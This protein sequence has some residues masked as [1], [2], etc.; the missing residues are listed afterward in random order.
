MLVVHPREIREVLVNPGMG[1]TTFQ[2]FQGD[3]LN[4]DGTWSEDGPLDFDETAEATV[5]QAYPQTSLAYCRWCWYQ[6]EPEPGGYR[7]GLIDSALRV[8]RRR[9]QRLAV[10]VAP[11]HGRGPVPEWFRRVAPGFTVGG[12]WLPDYS[13]PRYLATMA[14]LVEEMGRRYDGHPDLDTVDIAT[15]GH[16]GEWHAAGPDGTS[17]M[18]SLPVKQQVIDVY[19]HAFRRTPLLMQGD[20]EGLRYA[21]R[22]GTGWRVDCLG[23]MRQGWCHM[24]D[25]YPQLLVRAEAQ[26][27]WRH[28]PVALET[29]WTLPHWYAHGWDVDHIFRKALD[30]HVTS[31][32]AKSCPVPEPWRPQVDDLCRRMGYRLVLRRLAHPSQA[33]AGG[34]LPL[35]TYWDNVGVA[36]PYRPYVL[37]L[38][39]RSAERTCV[40]E[41]RAR[42]TEWVPGDHLYDDVLRLPDGMPPGTYEVAVALLDPW[43]RSPCIRLAVE[44]RASDGWY[45][46]SRLEVVAATD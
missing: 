28:A 3:P 31:I 8:A 26:D 16:C 45:P 10:R 1:F 25:Q 33:L 32:N 46:L 38:R 9:G 5:H 15:L 35:E 6:I 41:T 30:W 20:V 39:L 7:W 2:R 19:L 29:C 42:V 21:V 12:Q 18:P 23:D 40:V 13:H 17:L 44:G 37:G 36:P 43:T 24:L 22:R 14:R 11:H 4:P 34:P 27:A